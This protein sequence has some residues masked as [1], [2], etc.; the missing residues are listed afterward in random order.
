MRSFLKCF[1]ILALLINQM[2]NI[3]VMTNET[4]VI[5][6]QA[7]CCGIFF[8]RL[9]MAKSSQVQH[10]TCVKMNRLAS[11]IKVLQLQLKLRLL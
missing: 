2:N 10:D 3:C 1:F 6:S 8:V 9:H 4:S 5:Y 11:S 7:S